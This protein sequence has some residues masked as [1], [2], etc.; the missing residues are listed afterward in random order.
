M[1]LIHNSFI[2]EV[3]EHGLVHG[4]K[5]LKV[6]GGRFG[7]FFFL[8]GGGEGISAGRQGGGGV[9]FLLKIQ[10]GERGSLKGRGGAR[11][12][13]GGSAANFLGGRAK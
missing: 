1:L 10:G 8:L 11:G 5:R 6:L 9:G 7:F 13:A 3:S 12:P 4:S 2:Q